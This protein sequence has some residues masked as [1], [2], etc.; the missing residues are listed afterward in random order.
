[1]VLLYELL[2]GTTPFDKERLKT[3]GYDEIRRIIREEEPPKPSTRI[4]TLQ[5]Q[6]R[7][8]SPLPP[9]RSGERVGGGVGSDRPL[10]TV[11]G[12]IATIAEQRKSDP[13]RLSQLFRGE[14][15]WIVM[16]CLEKDRNRRYETPGAL[17]QDIEHYLHDEPVQACPPSAWYRVRKVTRRHKQAFVILSVVGLFLLAAVG[18]LIVSNVRI[19]NK[20]KEVDRANADLV[21]VNNDL[22]AN[23]Y[24]YRMALAERELATNHGARAEELLGQCKADQRG[25]EWHYLKRRIHEEPLVLTG[26][27]YGV[28]GVAFTPNGQVLA[29]A[30]WDGTVRLW[31]PITGKFLRSLNGKPPGFAGVGI[32]ANGQFLAAA[33]WD[34]TVT[35]WDLIANQERVVKGQANRANA[36]AFSP[37]SQF[38]A[39]SSTDRTAI[40]WDLRN[41]TQKM[42]LSDHDDDVKT[43][44]YNAQGTRLATGSDDRTV[45]IWDARTGQLLRTL[46][47]HQGIVLGVAFSPD[48][49]LV[50]S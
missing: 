39:W 34:G 29:S 40:V 10:T 43:V 13:K 18:L 47:G 3:A 27:T 48:G 24:L 5:S 41:N 8:L 46:P 28:S 21:D 12:S 25:W 35:V 1:G 36:V 17:A 6:H 38:L 49:R 33:N 26:H 42:V 16:K 32:S 20:Q 45:R 44:A 2:T 14:L 31:E 4:S 19:T 7:H 9:P 50:A 37:D 22:E 15:D 23:L 30:S 11:R